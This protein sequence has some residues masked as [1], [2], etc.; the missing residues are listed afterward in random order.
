[1]LNLDTVGRLGAGK[2]QVLGTG[3]ATRVAARS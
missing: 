1:M 3:T 2:I